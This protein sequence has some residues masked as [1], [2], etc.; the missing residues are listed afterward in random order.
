MIK[1]GLGNLMK[2]AQAMQEN[3]KSAQE[4]LANVEVEGQSGGGMVRVK[5][6][7]RHDVRG[8]SIDDAL[9][10]DDKDVLEDL[11]AA[12]MNDATRKIEQISKEKL[13][14]LTSGLNIPGLNLPF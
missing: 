7:C 1:G 9:L 8:V 13:G 4:E 12:A 10:G 2:Q 11:L 3:L 6:S 5:V 14:G